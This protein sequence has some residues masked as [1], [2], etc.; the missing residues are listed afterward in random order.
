[1]HDLLRIELG[2]RGLIFSDDLEMKAISE[3]VG[4]DVAACAAIEAGCDVVLICSN[5][6]YVIAAQR[7]LQLK[8]EREPAFAARLQDAALRSLNARAQHAVHPASRTDIERL[9]REQ[10]PERIEARIAAAREPLA[11]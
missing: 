5:P 11:S 3:R 2:F 6:D 9:L 8:A 4:V 1:V 10:Q 7:A